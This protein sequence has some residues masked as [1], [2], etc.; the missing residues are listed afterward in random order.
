MTYRE[1]LKASKTI[2]KAIKALKDDESIKV[3]YGTGYKGMPNEY[4]IKAYGKI[5]E[6]M[7][8]AIWNNFSGMNIEKLGP[9][10]AKAYSYDMMNQR[11]N[12]SFPLYE[13]TIVKRYKVNKDTI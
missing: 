3:L 2:I 6:D 8:Y 5:E 1:K 9:T 10:K 12:Y 13:M 7:S 4:T 11:T